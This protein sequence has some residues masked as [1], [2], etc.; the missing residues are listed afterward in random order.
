LRREGTSLRKIADWLNTNKFKPMRGKC[1]R[2]STVIRILA[3]PA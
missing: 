3:R 2:H 1:W